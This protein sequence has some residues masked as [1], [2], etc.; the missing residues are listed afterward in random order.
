VAVGHAYKKD[1][2][3]QFLL[4]F[5]SPVFLWYERRPSSP[6]SRSGLWGVLLSDIG[7]VGQ[8][9]ACHFC[10]TIIWFPSTTVEICTSLNS[11]L[12]HHSE[13]RTDWFY[14]KIR[15]LFAGNKHTACTRYLL[16]IW[17]QTERDVCL[18]TFAFSW[19]FTQRITGRKYFYVSIF[20]VFPRPPTPKKYMIPGS[21]QSIMVFWN[22][23]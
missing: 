17:K 3:P 14:D 16:Y 9:T 11:G 18:N 23:L 19:Y 8:N 21:P 1:A 7:R 6:K 5:N 2:Q 12:T 20:L 15:L 10:T 4:F 22:F 13:I